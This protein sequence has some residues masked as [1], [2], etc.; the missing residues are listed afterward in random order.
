[1]NLDE[2]ID[3]LEAMSEFIS[4]H[5]GGT[6]GYTKLDAAANEIKQLIR[7]VLEYVT[8]DHVQDCAHIDGN[9]ESRAI[10]FNKAVTEMEEKQ[11]E[12]GL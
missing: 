9:H 5:G 11:R 8:P 3:A 7:D 2:R 4:E 10:G 1:M 12:L 6:D